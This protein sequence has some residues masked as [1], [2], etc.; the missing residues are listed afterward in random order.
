LACAVVGLFALTDSPAVAAVKHEFLPGLSAKLDEPVPAVGPHG[1]TVPAPGPLRTVQS[2]TLDA[3]ELYVT[4]EGASLGSRIDVFDAVSGA[5][6][7]QFPSYRFLYSGIAVGHSTGEEQV[8]VGGTGGIGVL[9]S[10]GVLQAEWKGPEPANPP[11]GLFGCFACGVSTDQIAVDGDPSSLNDW[12]AGDVYVADKSKGVVDVFKPLAGGGEQYVAQLPGGTG[13][14]FSSPSSVAVSSSDGEVIVGDAGSEG[15]SPSVDVFKPAAL[16]GQYEFVG[17][18]AGSSFGQV[19]GVAVD[20]GSGAGSG[21]IYAWEE[22][23]VDQF[24]SAGKLIGRLTGTPTGPSGKEQAFR[25]VRVAIDQASHNVYVTDYHGEEP[26][27]VDVFGPDIVI[28]DVSTTPASGVKATGG[29]RIEARLNGTVNPDKEGEASCRF[30]WGSTPELG[31]LAPCEPEH[32]GEGASPVPV[33]AMVHDLAPDTIYYYRLQATNKNGT[34]LGGLAPPQQFTTPGPSLLNESA[35]NVTATSVTLGATILHEG[36][37]TYYFQY[38]K[39]NGYEAAVPLA[40]GAPLGSGSSEAEVAQHVQGLSPATVYHYRVVGVSEIAPREFESFFGVDQTFT[41]QPAAG[42]GGSPLLDGREWELVS[43][44]DKHGAQIKQ[45]EESGVA[46]AAVGGDAMTFLVNS[47]TEGEPSGYANQVQVLSTRGRDGWAARD[48]STPHE[49]ATGMVLGLGQEYQFFSEDLSLA[50]VQQFGS[51]NP[52][53]SAEASE[54]TPYLRTNFLHGNVSEGCVQS[55]YHPLVTGKS[56]YAN[57]AP[58]TVF[59]NTLA[60]TDD[61]EG[62]QC[63]PYPL[64]GPTFVDATPDLSRIALYSYVP[65]T[66]GS[67]G[68]EYEWMDGGLS[69]GNHLPGLR[70]STSEDGSWTYVA[71][72]SVLAPGAI[73]GECGSGGAEKGGLCNLYVSH[74]GVTKLIA[75]VPNEDQKDWTGE[76]NGKGLNARTSRV[77]PDGRWFAF[78]SDRSLTGYDNLDAVSGKPDEEVYLYHAPEDFA[79]EAGRLVCASCDPTGAR[80]VGV[81]YSKLNERLV[82]G[83]AVWEPNQWIAANIPGWTPNQLEHSL[84]QSRYLSDSGRLFFN[85]SD[86]LVP[87]DVNGNED[88]YEYEPPGVGGCTTASARFSERSD[89]CGGLISSGQSDGESAFLDA[90][91]NGGD[92]FFLTGSK[93]VSEDYDTALD[94]YDAHECNPQGPCFPASVAVPPPCGTGDACKA[95]PSPQPAIFGAPAS[96]TFAGTGNASAQEPG[97][98]VKAKSLTRAQKLARALKACQSKKSKRRRVCERQARARYAARASRTKKGR[99]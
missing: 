83:N 43:P 64:C 95:A 3:G 54:Q 31:Q 70:V 94:V 78:M 88:V 99:G 37:T 36:P 44:A 52:S 21:D 81:E 46:Q 55:C 51:F 68:G 73:P 79:S 29:G 18:L 16:A 35:S 84:Y 4:E 72:G 66:A 34:N 45:I 87:Q 71:S 86:A 6:V 8:Y 22:A 69:P 41:T 56:A 40:P 80:P 5:F 62:Q 48:I 39:S 76:S 38:G 60:S 14:A 57:V 90:S 75:V 42:S 82:G 59:G 50:V 23:S 28:P 63:P 89:G 96:A 25:S 32:V 24:D 47:P 53:L 97:P 13:V 15:S 98:V 9:N 1:E 85:S 19:D 12:A 30:E 27:T 20:S 17:K 10:A 49:R 74:D 61:H 7:S 11:G 33:H 26:A 93:L 77:S 91:G 58:G 2:T 65:L 67:S 92:V